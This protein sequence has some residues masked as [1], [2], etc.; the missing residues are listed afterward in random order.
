MKGP[1]SKKEGLYIRLPVSSSLLARGS[2]RNPSADIVIIF[3]NYC[4]FTVW[5]HYSTSQKPVLTQ[6]RHLNP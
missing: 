3:H 5:Q 6:A 2:F 4:I 1:N